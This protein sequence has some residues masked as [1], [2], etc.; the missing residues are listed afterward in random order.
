MSYNSKSLIDVKEIG[1]Y[2]EIIDAGL[3]FLLNQSKKLDLEANIKANL[4]SSG[5]TRYARSQIT[6]HTDIF[7]IAFTIVIM[8]NKKLTRAYTTKTDL[9]SLE[10]FLIKTKDGLNKVPETPFL[11]GLPDPK[12]GV[13]VD[14]SGREWS[15]EDRTDTVIE[16]VNA[17]EN[18][19]KDI[20]LAGTA[21][22][23]KSYKRI[24]TT[25]GVDV[26]DSNQS[27]YFK[28]NAITGDPDNRGYGEE[29]VYW[30]FKK[31]QIS[32]MAIDAS[33]TAIDTTK[34][35]DLP[36]PN[37]YEV[38]LAPT[39]VDGL[40][41]FV[42]LSLDPVS[43]H[44]SNTFATDRL[45]DQIFDK[46]LTIEDLPRDP[47]QA[48]IVGSFDNEGTPTSNKTLFDSGVLKFIP[49]NSFFASKFLEDKNLTTGNDLSPFSYMLSPFPISLSINAGSKGIDDQ[50]YEIED[51][52]YIKSFYYNRFTVRN[53][54]GLTGLTRNGLY[55]VKNGEIK[56]AVRNLRYTESF[57]DAFAP[58]NVISVSKEREQNFVV[59][60]P[61]IHLKK[62]HFS[63]VAHTKK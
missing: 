34:L 22:E 61:S 23:E 50:I 43:Y 60:S 17:A 63:S 62:Y 29:D 54:G 5:I 26:E 36:A 9:K 56:G 40:L 6:Q 25:N 15:I 41:T 45:G 19:R 49:Y 16:A 51:G 30:R 32:K 24:V 12:I 11:Q 31:P 27:N 2:Y 14:L 20:I 58:N 33:Q 44:E 39:A 4:L 1:E 53:K 47:H 28:T 38:L 57:V 35:I 21:T 8:K 37:D 46:K 48:N 13:V 59:N 3:D 18:I 7:S 10:R 42:A 52:L 55:Y